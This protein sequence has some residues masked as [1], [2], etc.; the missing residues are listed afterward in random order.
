MPNATT[1]DTPP[2]HAR[3][4]SST[5]TT[6]GAPSGDRRAIA[7]ENVLRSDTRLGDLVAT[8]RAMWEEMPDGKGMLGQVLAL[9]ALEVGLQLGLA[10]LGKR[11]LDGVLDGG[12]LD[13]RVGL[14]AVAL[15]AA[16]VFVSWQRQV[17]QEAAALLWRERAVARLSRNIADGALE[18]LSAVPMAGL[19]EIVMTDAPF[20]TRF[21]VETVTQA[22]VLGL[23]ILAALGFLALYGPPLLL[24][25]VL[26][27][28]LCG[29]IMI[30]GSR[31]HLTMT[32]ERFRRLATLSQSARDVVEVERVLLTRQF[33]LGDRFVRGFAAAH[34]AFRTV[35]LRQ[36]RLASAIR[37]GMSVLNA[38]GFLGLVLVGGW[39]VGNAA[40]DPGVLLA[41]LFVVGQMLTA[42][43][44]M[45]DIAGRA[46]EAATAGRRLSVYW[47]AEPGTGGA[48]L[49]EAAARPE[50]VRA[51]ETHDLG[52]GYEARRPVFEHVGLRIERGALAALTAETGA[53]KSTFART[54]C[55]LLQPRAGAVEVELEPA[56][57]GDADRDRVPIGA[58]PPGSVLYLGASP[59]LLPGS[60]R[61]NLM[62]PAELAG[63]P[64]ESIDGT[65]DLAVVREALARDGVPLDWSRALVD[66]GGNGLSSGQSQLVQ[67]ARALVRDPAVVVFDEATSSLDM[68]T[69]Q[70]V[71]SRLVDW[72][73]RR[74]C[75][76]ISHRGCPWLDA[77]ERHLRW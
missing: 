65:D 24:V 2:N 49:A 40:L 42:V 37:A 71:Q 31:R 77:A 19:R 27:L 74:V 14:L 48:P 73:R 16:I 10:L 23:W 72:C 51:I 75:L 32:A 68:E 5:A 66:A 64:L 38:V 56:A 1:S 76:V 61:D 70:L 4:T 50:R 30:G 52:F 13:A 29:A 7:I 17:R 39:L 12:S 36:G 11:L 18:D 26:L 35:A 6:D 9:S 47:N 67:L 28:G 58:L 46:A 53:G 57:S 69:E 25:I 44:Q 34:G 33:G 15:L 54:L 22:F 20:I 63:R 41:A 59:I 43:I 55:G 60:L 3:G 21:G 8:V 45:G 62:L